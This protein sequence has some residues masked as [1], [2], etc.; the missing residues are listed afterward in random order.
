[1]QGRG[2]E[3]FFFG[4]RHLPD[5]LPVKAGMNR[6]IWDMRYPD[7]TKLKGA[8]L[9]AG[10]TRGPLAV[11]GTY[12]A[13]LKVGDKILT[14]SFEIKKDPRVPATIADLQ[15]QFDLLIKIRDKVSQAHEAVQN[16]RDIRKQ[17]NSVVER[18]KGQ[19]GADTIASVAKSLKEKLKAIEEKII[20][21]KAKARQD[22]LNYPIKLNNKL[23]ALASV[24]ASADAKPTKQAY[25]VFDDL[26]SRLDA[27]LAKLNEIIEKDIPAF[28][29]LVREQEIPA[30]FLRKKEKAMSTK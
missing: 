9:W 21:V 1:E 12:Q 7:A 18:V 11:P 27:Q 15:E 5:T 28:N 24:V 29:Q 2:E 25:E 10:S 30:V 20:Q 19:A 16:I 14:K 8:I 4:E 13:R 3:D 26:S 22:V 17:V 23:A 6:F